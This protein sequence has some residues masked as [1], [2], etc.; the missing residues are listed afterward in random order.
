M[1]DATSF[2]AEDHSYEE[3]Q[4]IGIELYGGKEPGRMKSEITL[5]YGFKRCSRCRVWKPLS[6]FGKSNDRVDGHNNKCRQ[7]VNDYLT[8]WHNKPENRTKRA[9]YTRR[10]RYG[11]P[12]ARERTKRNRLRDRC[13]MFGITVEQYEAM[14][15]KQGG[16]CAMC[17]KTE[18]ENGRLLAIDHDHSCCPDKL[19][20]CGK[21]VRALLCSTCNTALGFYEAELREGKCAAYLES[22]KGNGLAA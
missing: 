4:A 5:R 1:L 15:E 21:C 20:S 13:K 16:K 8:G 14:Y 19:S 10:S 6:G 11:S 17:A 7:C 3:L 22:V 2:N 9:E 12:E 18:E